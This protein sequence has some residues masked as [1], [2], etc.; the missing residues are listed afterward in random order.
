[1]GTDVASV[2]YSKLVSA[3]LTGV[4]RS[5]LYYSRSASYASRSS[6]CL[7]SSIEFD[8]L[9][10]VLNCFES[11]SLFDISSISVDMLYLF[12]TAMLKFFATPLRPELISLVFFDVKFG[13]ENL[14]SS[15]GSLL[16]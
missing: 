16:C 4:Q 11:S 5:T 6:F 3:S 13:T 12:L 10:S 7:W 14:L 15:S 9:R 2:V 8:S 1:M